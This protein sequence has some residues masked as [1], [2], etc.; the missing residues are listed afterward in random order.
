M[1]FVRKLCL[2]TAG[3]LPLVLAGCGDSNK[4]KAIDPQAAKLVGVW[5]GLATPTAMEGGKKVEVGNP[6]TLKF[7]FRGD[8][9]MMM[10][11]LFAPASGTWQLVKTDGKK[12]TVLTVMNVPSGSIS[13]KTENGKTVRTEEFKTH[14]EED[15]FTVVFETDDRIEMSRLEDPGEVMTLQRRK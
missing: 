11:M 14:K 15:T 3:L 13:E 10:D 2:S 5:E 1:T 9:T 6:V 12:L 8:G 4:T 7:E